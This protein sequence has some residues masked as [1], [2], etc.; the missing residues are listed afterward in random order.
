MNLRPGHFP[1]FMSAI[2][3][4]RPF[5]WQQRLVEDLAAT[6]AWPDV[7]D[8]PTGTGKTAAL[9]A[10][11]FH[12]ALRAD[13]PYRAAIRIALVVD[14]RL[15]VDAAFARA[16]RIAE[17][18][19][20][21]DARQAH[22]VLDQ[23]A[24][25]LQA[26]AGEHE[27]PL[28]AARLRGGAPLENIW[29]RSPTQPA[30]LCSTVDQVGSRLLF[31]GYGVSDP[32]KPI[33]AGLL[34]EAS[35]ILLDE[36]HLSAPFTETLDAVRRVGGARIRAVFL[37]AT[38]AGRSKGRLCLS[39]ADR[40]HSLLRRRIAAKKLTHL[41]RLT[42]AASNEAERPFVKEAEAMMGRLQSHSRTPAVGIVVNRVAL[43]RSIHRVL[44]QQH[45]CET[46]LLIGR[47]RGVDRDRIADLLTPFLTGSD[48]QRAHARPTFIVA[49]QC[50]E[51]GVD[52]D[53]DGLVTQVASLDA[54]RQRFGRLNRSGMVREA[55]GAV[56]ALARDIARRADDPVYGDRIRKTW[57]ALIDA[58][59]EMELDFGSEALTETL[60][61]DTGGLS[62]PRPDAPVVMPAYLDLW[63]QTSPIPTSD[64]EVGLFLHGAEKA[65]AD[66]SIIWR[67]DLLASDLE[68]GLT[69][70]S[71]ERSRALGELLTVVP[72]R[73]A[74]MIQV[75][76][77]AVRRWLSHDAE[78][79]DLGE[80]ADAVQRPPVDEHRPTGPSRP[81][82]RWAG[83]DDPRTGIIS[84]RQLR[85]GDVIVV[86]AGYGGC[87]EYG[88][89]PDQLEAVP[90]VA[91]VRRLATGA[92]RMSVR[93]RP[94]RFGPSVRRRLRSA[95]ALREGRATNDL[96][97]HLLDALCPDREQ[98]LDESPGE[99]LARERAANA[100]RAIRHVGRR[101]RL[102]RPYGP[103]AGAGVVLSAAT[104]STQW[105]VTRNL[106]PAT[107][108]VSFSQGYSS[109][110]CLDSHSERV[111][112]QAGAFAQ[113][114]GLDQGT[115]SDL[116]LAAYLHDAGK[117]D[118]RFQIFLSGG[119]PWNAP[120]SEQGVLAKS[121]RRSARGAWERARL[122]ERWRHEALSVRLARVHPRLANAHDPALVLWLI[123]THHGYGR[124]F[125]PFFDPAP[126]LP[127]PALGITRWDLRAAGCGPERPGFDFLG[128]DWPGLAADLR[129]R[130]G[131][132]RVAF[133]EAVLRLAD[134]RA[135]EA[136]ESSGGIRD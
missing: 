81:A 1:A 85:P 57:E 55:P 56:L 31:R 39:D 36:A 80:L 93:L 2:H 78:A 42:A 11:V 65:P 114:L 30:L 119:N 52:L 71:G 125:F 112:N 4:H 69:A 74:E 17:A 110:V 19:C 7:L 72:P 13:E 15:V 130:L 103:A 10:A 41:R 50:L 54:L 116:R 60:G 131:T 109:P 128:L 92:R 29:V 48:Q 16:T 38:P 23:V 24:R 127:R 32:M 34:G 126:V 87:D 122:P 132:W 61:P 104:G 25:R 22:P 3:G 49:T 58:A 44:E 75:P 20:S 101:R 8:L 12:L 45:E 100:L 102:L 67:D 83:P 40:S 86:P 107:E 63:A 84:G 73:A 26:L 124:P 46:M 129:R 98:A 90:D 108:D 33:H 117:A 105:S 66:V 133:L 14:R 28:V 111:A 47:S 89:N 106:T 82:F 62:A 120:D 18:L 53:L 35:L 70:R 21:N 97:E 136:E 135:S 115:V 113:T 94:A 96:L 95:L 37:T 51:V 79:R 27:A 118:P 134:H 76:L 77:A 123:G 5:P 6:D 64:P 88:W 99:A 68:S 43:A 121:G 59:P 91:D 9:D